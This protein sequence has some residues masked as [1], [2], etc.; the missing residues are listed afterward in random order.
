MIHQRL[1][2]ERLPDTHLVGNKLYTDY[3]FPLQMVAVLLLV[4]T[5]GCVVLSKKNNK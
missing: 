5:V 4:A 2:D 1:S 3:N